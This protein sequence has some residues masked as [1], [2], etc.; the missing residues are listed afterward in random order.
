MGM[1]SVISISSQGPS[2]G[3]ALFLQDATRNAVYFEKNKHG[4]FMYIGPGSEKTWNFEKYFDDPEGNWDEL[5][6]QV[7]NLYLVQKHPILD[8]CR[9]FQKGD[10]KK[11]VAN[12][13]FN[14]DDPSETMFMDLISSANDFCIVF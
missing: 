7:T 2:G 13:H 10:L 8:R 9:H 12:T 5:A 3:N 1:M 14:A 11:G 6:K 4:Y